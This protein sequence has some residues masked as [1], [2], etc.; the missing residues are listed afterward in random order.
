MATGPCSPPEASTDKRGVAV[1]GHSRIDLRWLAW[2]LKV[3]IDPTEGELLTL[4]LACFAKHAVCQATIVAVVVLDAHSVLSGKSF[5]G[6]LCINGLGI[7]KVAHHE[8]DQLAMGEV[9]NKNGGV[10]IARFGECAFCLAIKTWLCQLHVID[11]DALPWLGGGKDGMA[12]LSVLFGAP[13]NFGH[14]PKKAA[15]ASGWPNLCELGWDLAIERELFQFGEGSVAETIMPSHQLGLIIGSCDRVLVIV[16]KDGRG[17][18][19]EGITLQEVGM[20]GKFR[21]RR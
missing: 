9:V 17:V 20:R 1:F 14:G 21:R 11:R 6:A 12:L 10:V 18:K 5:K 19:S 2:V 7:G 16:I 15:S 8:V 3:G 4:S 13:R